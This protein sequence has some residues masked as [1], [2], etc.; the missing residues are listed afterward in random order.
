MPIAS[1]LAARSHEEWLAYVQPT[2]LVVSAKVLD[3]RVSAP[4]RQTAADTAAVKNVLEGAEE[5]T[6]A[7]AWAFAST[8]LGWDAP[9]VA[10]APGGPELPEDARAPLPEHHTTLRPD[11]I[12][13]ADANKAHLDGVVQDDERACVE[14]P[15]EAGAAGRC[16]RLRR[17]LYGMRS[18]AGA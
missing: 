10:G 14:L 15:G 16:G 9:R 11:W 12:V 6:I 5:P 2:G 4:E 1:N 17:W 8:V 3:E 7:D 13:L 18:A